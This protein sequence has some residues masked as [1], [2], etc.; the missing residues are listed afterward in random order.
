MKPDVSVA[1][2]MLS[3]FIG[4]IKPH[5]YRFITITYMKVLDETCKPEETNKAV[6]FTIAIFRVRYL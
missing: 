5:S 6:I 2:Q 4:I 1:V 3:H